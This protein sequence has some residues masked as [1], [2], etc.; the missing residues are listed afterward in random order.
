MHAVIVLDGADGGDEGRHEVAQ[1]AQAALVIEGALKLP[2]HL[3]DQRA[4]LVARTDG[5]L[6]VEAGEPLDVLEGDARGQGL[7]LHFGLAR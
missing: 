6:Q 5:A 7:H 2:A 4:E 3:G 1:P